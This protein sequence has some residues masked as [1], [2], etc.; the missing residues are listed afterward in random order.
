MSNDI[1]RI[2]LIAAG[3]AAGTLLRYGVSGWS[4]GLTQGTFPIGTLAVNVIGCLAIGVAGAFFSS[5][6]TVREAYRLMIMIGL[7]GGFTTFS[8]FGI[9]TVSL[10]DDRQ[11]AAA[12]LNVLLQNGL[13][14]LAAWLGYRGGQVIFGG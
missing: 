11:F 5:A 12:L 4:Q 3:G 9:E 10:I 8:S 14:L 2:V 7:L 6:Q 13:G 1:I